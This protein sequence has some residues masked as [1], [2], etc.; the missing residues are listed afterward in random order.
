MIH[1]L[2]SVQ[3][4]GWEAKNTAL[5]LCSWAA[6]RVRRPRPEA[7]AH[8]RQV[9]VVKLDHL[10][11]GLL[12]T[13]VLQSLRYRYPD[14]AIDVLCARWN[15]PAFET[16]PFLRYLM[17]LNPRHYATW[18]GA[19]PD[20]GWRA[21]KSLRALR[22]RYDLILVLRGSWTTLALAVHPG[23]LDVSALRVEMARRRAR[24]P[25]DAHELDRVFAALEYGG[26]KLERVAPIYPIPPDAREEAEELL[27]RLGLSPCRLIA[28][29]AGTPNLK[30]R[31]LAARWAHLAEL[32]A[33]DGYAVL[34]LGS[35]A[36]EKLNAEIRSYCRVPL[37]DLSGK[38]PLPL[39]AALL[40][41]CRCFVG[42]DSGPMHLAALV[43]A[44]TLGLFFRS[45]SDERRWRPLGQRTEVLCSP[46][47]RQLSVETTYRAVCRMV[48]R[49]GHT[50]TKNSSG[51]ALPRTE[52]A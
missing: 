41:R 42:V 4:A 36:D 3:R 23:Y 27:Q 29:H 33:A 43:G 26:L 24:L 20:R 17:Q 5:V 16:L 30:K 15:R 38:T 6:W 37:A 11:D 18:S 51:N 7:I 52:N 39:T 10:G 8:P 45:G 25:A 1:V 28:L 21:W 31:W 19:V 2:E 50:S 12:A 44:P 46:H 9:L 22:G 34:L 40:E 35:R 47:P 48:A 32:L 13:A 14:A 49:W